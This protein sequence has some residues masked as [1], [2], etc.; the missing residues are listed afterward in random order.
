MEEDINVVALVML[1]EN[2]WKEFV[3]CSGSEE[4]AEMTLRAL[5]HAAGMEAA[6]ME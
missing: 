6:D 4:S 2:N 1:V 5:R 3:E